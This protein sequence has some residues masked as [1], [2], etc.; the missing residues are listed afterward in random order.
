MSEP[1]TSYYQ[2]AQLAQAAYGTFSPGRPSIDILKSSTVEFPH[3]LAEAF[4]RE[5][6]VLHQIDDSVTGF[7]ATLFQRNDGQKILA[8]RGTEFTVADLATDALIGLFGNSVLNPQYLAL[9]DYVERLITPVSQNGPGLGLIDVAQGE[10]FSIAGHSLGGYLGSVLT[11]NSDFGAHVSQVY[12][13][14]A[15]GTGGALAQLLNT[16]GILPQNIADAKITNLNTD[17]GLS[18]IAGLG[19][20]RGAVQD[21]FIEEGSSVHNHSIVTLTD[22]LALYNL[23]GTIDPNVEVESITEIL[24]AAGTSGGSSLESTLFALRSL[25]QTPPNSLTPNTPLDAQ[26][27]DAYYVNIDTVAS[28]LLPTGTYSVES[29]TASPNVASQAEQSGGLAYRYALTQLNPF[30]I[31]GADYARHNTDGTLDLYNPDTGTGTLTEE[32]LHDRA[33]F[34]GAKIALNLADA[35][36]PGLQGVFFD[37]RATSYTIAPSLLTTQRFIFGSDADEADIDG[38]GGQDR[39]YGGGGDDT[40]T[41]LDLGDYLEG[42]A[43]NDTL[44][45]GSG[46]DTLVG[47]QGIDTLE[48]GADNDVLDG[49]LD[50]DILK[51]GA[52]LDR[53]IIRAVDGADTIEDS[54]GK[55]VVEFGGK[56]L[57]SGLRRTDDPANVFHSA[58]GTITL[59]KQ[60]VDL[61]VTGSG[62]LTIKNFATGQFG[63]RLVGEAAY[64]PVTRDTFLKTIPDPNNPP[65]ATI[66]VAFFDEGNNH[67]NNLE[68]PLTDGTNNLIHALGG[69]DTIISG[70][71]DDQLYGEGDNDEIYGGLGNDRLYGG[72]GSDQLFGDNVAVST[73]GGND[74]LD[75]GEGNDLVQGGAGRDIVFGGAGNDNLN[76]D[77]FAGDNSGGFDDYLDGEAGDDELHGAAGSD[78]LIGG[79]GNDLLIGDT[80][81]FQNG[82]PEQGGND[83]LDGGE[84]QD[85]LFGL[86]GDDLLSGGIGDDLVNGQDGSDVLYGGEGNDTLSGDLRI[87]ALGG[88]YDTREYRAAGADDLLFGEAGMD[89][90]SG[91]E[92]NDVVDGGTENDTLYGDYLT[93]QISTSDPLYWTLFSA[94][95]DDWLSGGTGNDALAG[96]FGADVLLGGDGTDSLLGG[97][98]DDLLEGGGGDDVLYGEYLLTASEFVFNPFVSDITALSGNDML[99]GGDGTD[100]L[101]GGEGSDTLLGGPGTILCSMANQGMPL[102]EITTSW[103][104]VPATIR[105]KAGWATMCSM[106]VRG[107]IG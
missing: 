88:G 32:Y 9:K 50:N 48:G 13:Y 14:N 47:Q 90:L 75:G 37:D 83:S 51:G 101:H 102:S 81:Q 25:F 78:V 89:L 67:S 103:T 107:T 2:Y 36:S 65:P 93:S 30:V 35:S 53:Y 69:A 41:G 5:Y 97:E 18:L 79:A 59:T 71:G 77:E 76:G 17:N 60:G 73:S 20:Q 42:N 96:G 24:N 52:G 11:A 27:R 74:F 84:G 80:T 44:L 105:L 29:L 95:G 12:A 33:A 31:H 82:T 61:V 10:Q 1:L 16:L 56:I 64:A 58:D 72:L 85:Q 40:L 54:D 8:I 55:G 100:I 70:A 23:I 63:V 86:Y 62:P 91:G 19:M 46:D 4:S 49:G 38:G 99:D 66:Q 98:G 6:T 7:S 106:A 43:G 26:D 87:V 22:A 68:D 94:L 15:P 28:S 45:G 39:L 92:G 3:F 34:L 104:G 21:I 57:L